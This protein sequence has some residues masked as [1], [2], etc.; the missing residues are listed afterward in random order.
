[1]IAMTGNL[2]QRLDRVYAAIADPTRRAI[3]AK[4]AH[5]HVNVGDLAAR[6]PISLNGVS[7]H[8]KVLERAG[9]VR[10]EILGREHQ[11]RLTAEP[12]REAE[13]WFQHYRAFWIARLDALESLLA[14]QAPQIGVGHRAKKTKRE[15]RRSG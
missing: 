2:N 10:R 1:M 13:E 7:K 6:F 9:L 3:L 4:L 8:V 14:T 5:G 11:L 12:L 15:G